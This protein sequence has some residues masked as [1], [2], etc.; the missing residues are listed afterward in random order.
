MLALYNFILCMK[1]GLES[2][3]PL[4]IHK[5]R[6][7]F[8]FELIQHFQQYQKLAAMPIYNQNH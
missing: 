8:A 1:F 3:I 4:V 5:Y 2:Y 7:V 6:L